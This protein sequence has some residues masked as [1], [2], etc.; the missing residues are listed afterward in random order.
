MMNIDKLRIIDAN[1]NRAKEATRVLEDISRFLLRNENLTKKYRELRHKLDNIIDNNKTYCEV[2]N[3]RAS[4]IDPGKNFYTKNCNDIQGILI[5]NLQRGQEALRVLEE[6]YKTT[7]VKK[8]NTCMKL[9]FKF[10]DLAKILLFHLEP[11]KLPEKLLY[12]IGNKNDWFNSNLYKKIF[13][14]KPFLVQFRDDTIT[15]SSYYKYLQN[16]IEYAQKKNVKI[17]INNR[18]DMCLAAESDGVHIGKN[19]LPINVVQNIIG[20]NKIIGY[21]THTIKELIK[22]DNIKRL[23]YIS[24]G[25]IFKS[26][27]KPNRPFY[28]EPILNKLR[29]ISLQKSLVLIG[30]INL[31]N[32]DILISN[33]FRRVAISN[34]IFKSENPLSVVDKLL[35]KIYK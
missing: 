33:G 9:R 28:G 24:F 11:L 34:A 30:G 18:V 15:D 19:D 26:M 27:T 4:N 10:Y 20:P 1:Y 17:I 3:S 25:T 13:D 29:Q 21:T 7:S 32:I 16:L 31:N 22:A 14:R 12:I 23:N 5:A 6:I 2:I 35:N 8:S